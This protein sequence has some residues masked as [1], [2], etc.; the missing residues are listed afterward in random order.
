M[1][2]H[3]EL[4]RARVGRSPRACGSGAES[5]CSQPTRTTREAGLSGVSG[6]YPCSSY[7]HAHGWLT[8]SRATHATNRPDLGLY[9]RKRPPG[10]AEP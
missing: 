10:G 7:A 3:E 2:A 9:L 5:G 8:S 4:I 6:A 1:T